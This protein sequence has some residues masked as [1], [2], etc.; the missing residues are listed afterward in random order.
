MN[1][2]PSPSRPSSTRGPL[3]LVALTWL[4]MVVG[5]A[6]RASHAGVACP[7]WPLCH[8]H[9][10]PPLD[11]TFYPP[12]PSYAVFRVYLEF[13]HRVV[14]GLVSLVAVYVAARL[15]RAHRRLALA[16][17]A[18]LAAQVTMGAVTVRLRNAPYTVVIH[19]ALALTF[20]ATAL[21][22]RDALT[23]SPR[24]PR[25]IAAAPP[26][27]H[28]GY[29]ALWV[30]LSAQMLLGAVV[31]SRSL[32]LA[33]A[34]FPLCNGL[35]LPAYWTGP[36]A[37]QYAHRVLGFSALLGACA[38]WAASVLLGDAGRRERGRCAALV[39]GLLAQIVLGGINVWYQIP[40]PASAAHL[41]LAAILFAALAD[42]IIA[43]ARARAPVTH[44]TPV[45]RGRAALP[46]RRSADIACV[47]AKARQADLSL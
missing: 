22:A 39:A 13:G 10:V 8:G 46:R 40:P 26:A 36:I 31:S 32:G 35:P 45:E 5:A 28:R 3:A 7:D 30:V 24:R 44:G 12:N 18:V 37:W 25:A 1:L 43:S 14:A 23:G 42:R 29:V 17:L 47:D 9:W 38:L 19:L 34:D 11:A 16:L 33:C 6:T 41:G 2:S 15:G 20:L 4:L 21:R 27:L